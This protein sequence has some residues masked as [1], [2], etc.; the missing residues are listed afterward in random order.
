MNTIS[1]RV[2]S[3]QNVNRTEVIMSTVNPEFHQGKLEDK[4]VLGVLDAIENNSAV[5]QRSVA[6]ELGIAL[7]LANAYVKTCARKGLIK[8]SQVPRRRYA[9]Y[10]TPQGF[11]EKSR[12]TAS[13]LLHSFS[14]FR[15]ARTQ[16]VELLEKSLAHGQRRLVLIGEGELAEIA[17]L[18]GRDM[19]ADIVGTIPASA[20]PKQ[21]KQS[22][23]RLGRVDAAFVTALVSSREVFEAAIEALGADRVHVP[24]LL[25]VH[26][27]V[28]ADQ[29]LEGEA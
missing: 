26:P 17:T 6:N 21:L 2:P 1:V 25:R 24:R 28:R 27:Q 13:Y 7:G 29:P 23:D 11:A 10:L 14:F 15:G 19:G 8:V 3:V 4:I 12:L 20:D 16:C 5:T 9:Y 22:I 18:V